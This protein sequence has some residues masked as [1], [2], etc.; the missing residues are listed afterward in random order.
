L[1]VE[2]AEI[3]ND[4]VAIDYIVDLTSGVTG[5]IVELLRQSA[6]VTLGLETV[7]L[8]IAG[9]LRDIHNA[10]N[11]PGIDFRYLESTYNFGHMD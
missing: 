1:G 3:V 8:S 5:R 7:Q 6:R 4:A 10:I 2:P 9:L 11:A